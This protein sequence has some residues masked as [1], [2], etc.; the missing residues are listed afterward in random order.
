MKILIFIEN[1]YR[2]GL[3]SFL[4]SLINNWPNPNDQLI[5]LCNQ[6]HPGIF[7]IKGRIHRPFKF[8]AHR[9]AMY[10]D[11][12]LRTNRYV[13]LRLFRKIFSPFIRFIYFPYYIFR[14]RQ[15]F[16]VLM[17]DCLMIVNGGHP[18]GDT[19]R[20]AAI[21]WAGKPAKCIYNFHNIAVDYRW[22]ERWPDSLIDSLVVQNS[23]FLIGVSRFCASSIQKRIGRNAMSNVIHILNG[24]EVPKLNKD[25]KSLHIRQDLS[26]PLDGLLCLMLASYER[27]KGHDFLLK[28]FKK[29]VAEIPNAYLMICGHG[30]PDEVS[31]VRNLISNYQLEN[32]VFLDTFRADASSLIQVCDLL[33]VA[34]QS[35]ESF[36][37]VCAE[38]M[39]HS[40][41]V[42]ATN[43]GGIPEVV[44]DDY[45][46][47][48]FD[49]DDV[50][51]YANK[52]IQL[53]RS[54]AL[55]KI[56]GERGFERYHTLFS[57]S[58]MAQ[59]YCDIVHK[60][61]GNQL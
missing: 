23:R 6:S 56:Q 14:L 4:I 35:Y 59:Q 22:F 47:Y 38:A 24:V 11:L 16:S 34:S 49:P 27:R 30:Y 8:I 43:V 44:L 21:A 50:D 17:P 18:G 28:A 39:S 61:N 55:R 58:R 19:C 3:D 52:I 42:V 20:A 33:L 57:A 9:M 48:C 51:G 29:V 46:G 36:G 5:V 54:E 13:P 53:L 1:T 41:P 26:I 15:Y 32:N 60:I 37:L 7:D 10:L 45:G 12:V 2:G 25:S 40:I 31:R